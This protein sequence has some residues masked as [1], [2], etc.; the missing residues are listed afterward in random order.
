MAFPSLFRSE[1]VSVLSDRG[2]RLYIWLLVHADDDGRSDIWP[3]ELT[4]G[5]WLNAPLTPDK[6]WAVLLEVAQTGLIHLYKVGDKH[7]YQVAKWTD[8]QRI[9]RDRYEASTYPSPDG[10]RPEFVLQPD[11]TPNAES[12]TEPAAKAKAELPDEA[13]RLALLLRSLIL[14]NDAKARVPGEDRITSW[15]GA[16]DKLNRIDGREWV[17]IEA[18]I[19]WCQQ[20]SFWWKNILGG[21]KLRKQF[22][23]LNAQMRERPRGTAKKSPIDKIATREQLAL[24][25]KELSEH[26]W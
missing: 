11:V 13:R 15:V 14:K 22:T 3:G 25:A 26:G 5:P 10:D 1:K 18:V 2:F 24:D 23:Q 17:E 21:E 6:A 19:R 7:Y 9:R 20:D 12:V 8:F 4:G 16:I